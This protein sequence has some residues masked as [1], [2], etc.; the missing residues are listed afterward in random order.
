MK[1]LAIASFIIS[2]F[3]LGSA[4]SATVGVGVG[5]GK[6]KMS[7]ALRPGG[8]YQLPLLPVL[9]TGDE[10]SSYIVGVDY[11]D[12]Q[13]EMKPAKDWFS[14]T[15]SKFGLEPGR[16]QTVTVN[17][18][19][20]LKTEPGD[21]FAFLEAHPDVKVSGGGTAVGVAAASKLYFTVAPSN[22]FQALYYKTVFFFGA[23]S[24]WTYI[25][26]A[27]IIAAVL[28]YFLRKRFSFNISIG[29]K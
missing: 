13:P 29:K 6:I 10:T 3:L 27:V 8:T 11:L 1:K 4:A 2:F 25:V 17:L 23:Y 22:I 15:P 18:T 24:P 14:F 5:L 16:N 7:E 26:L 9:N 21:Y 20:P 28:I 19:I 12:N